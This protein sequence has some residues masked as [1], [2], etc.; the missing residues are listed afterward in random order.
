M[1]A[2]GTRHS[3]PRSKS[4]CFSFGSFFSSLSALITDTESAFESNNSKERRLARQITHRQIEGHFNETH[5]VTD[6]KN[7]M[8]DELH[9]AV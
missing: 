1:T 5:P 2:G 3:K 6:L 7:I 4:I 9:H 8:F